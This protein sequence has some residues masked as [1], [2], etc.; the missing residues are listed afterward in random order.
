MTVAMSEL[1]SRMKSFE[2]VSQAA[3]SAKDPEAILGLAG[4]I[5]DDKGE[6]TYASFFGRQKL[7]TGSPPLNLETTFSL[8][9]AGK[10]LTHIAAMQLVQAGLI[11]L[12]EPIERHVPEF[13]DMPLIYL[14]RS[15]DAASITLTNSNPRGYTTRPAGRSL[16]LRHFLTNS[17]GIMGEDHPLATSWETHAVPGSPERPVWPEDTKPI[18]KLC[19]R[20]LIHEPGDGWNYGHEVHFLQVIIESVSG[21]SFQSYMK[22]KVFDVLA[23]DSTTYLP[24]NRQDVLERQLE[25]VERVDGLLRSAMD[26]VNGLTCSLNDVGKIMLDLTC[27]QP[28]LLDVKTRAML[29][30]SGLE[31]QALEGFRAQAGEFAKQLELKDA[32]AVNYSLAGV[33]LV[34]EDGQNVPAGTL[35][36]DGMANVA[37][38]TNLHLGISTV[39][40]TQL[41]PEYDEHS[42][43][44][45]LEFFRGAFGA[46]Q[47]RI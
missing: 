25:M 29:Y 39:F 4:V 34:T 11:D 37:W 19:W 47:H 18:I 32:T 5:W 45:R 23:L 30:R 31:G 13:K 36:W 24:A 41:L 46:Q 40:A 6:T 8:Y 3:T 1:A 22:E 14:S 2:A 44:P 21:Q 28:R 15:D 38:A 17:T 20:P 35:T 7:A 33:M 9:S 16:T 26:A 12:D 10:F 43:R 27:S 42:M